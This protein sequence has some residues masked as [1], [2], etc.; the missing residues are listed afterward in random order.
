MRPRTP[1]RSWSRRRTAGAGDR[2][3]EPLAQRGPDGQWGFVGLSRDVCDGVE[4]QVAGRRA[5][6]DVDRSAGEDPAGLG[7]HVPQI[8][9]EDVHGHALRAARRQPDLAESAQ[10]LGR[11]LQ[12]SRPVADVDLHDLRSVPAAGVRERERD[13]ERDGILDRVH[14]DAEVAVLEGGVGEAVPEG[15]VHLE[16]ARVVPAVADVDSLAV[17]DV[18]V[19]TREVEVGRR[20]LEPDGHGL[21]ELARRVDG[22]RGARP[23][24]SRRGPGR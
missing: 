8:V 24:R 14:G 4:P 5:D 2:V 22:R 11:N 18:P 3:R 17:P 10:L 9:A 15:V 13:G 7:V 20:V 6:R 12:R 16:A 1:P 23:P 21:G 19:L